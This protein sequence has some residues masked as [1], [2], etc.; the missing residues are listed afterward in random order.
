MR[1]ISFTLSVI[2]LSCMTACQPQKQSF[3]ESFVEVSREN[4]FYFCLSNGD[5]YIPVGLNICWAR[6]MDE[7]ERMF[8]LLGENGGNFTR[9]W[10][11]GMYEYETEYDKVNEEQIAKV[12]KILEFAGKYGIKV[13][14]CIDNFRTIKPEGRDFNNKWAYHVDQGGPFTDM[15]DYMSDERGQNVFL[16]RVKFF[17]NRYGDDPRVFAWEIW[18]EMNA[19]SIPFDDKEKV[20]VP[21][22]QA[23]MAKMQD[24]FPKNLV[25]QSMGSLD[26]VR[27]FKQYEGIM[28]IPENDLI[29]VHRYIDE[30][31]SLPICQAP[32]DLLAADAINHLKAYRVYKPALLAEVGAVKPGHTGAHEAYRVDLDGTILHDILFAPFFTGSAG[33]GHAWH[34]DNYV[35][36]N[37][38]W[39]HFRRFANAIEGIDPVKEDFLPLRTD[40]AEFR[41]YVL[42][43]R[44]SSLVWVRDSEN[45]WQTELMEG[46]APTLRSKAVLNLSDVF[47]NSQITQINIY[48]PWA[49]K[50]S[51]AK[52][53]PAVAL[54]DFKRSIVLKINH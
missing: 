32:M 42:K 37:N 38:L 15:S 10:L 24:I 29:Q 20:L 9:V 43:G 52:A 44:K 54:P 1:N 3:D 41:V 18:N 21:W 8:R 14:M 19:I 47:K 12:D 17:K 30:G 16:N 22:N 39:H 4:P 48:D 13:K 53:S 27:Y 7:M 2:L 34:W 33:P 46:I 11:G 49:D 23:V 35:D 51:N 26:N 45:T 36:R 25:T 40:Q 31:A 28:R 6:N 50:W 5:T